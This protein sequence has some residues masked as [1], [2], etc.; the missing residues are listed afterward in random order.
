M[1][2]CKTMTFTVLVTVQG[3]DADYGDA[4]AAANYL[5]AGLEDAD[6]ELAENAENAGLAPSNFRITTGQPMAADRAACLAGVCDA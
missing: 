1:C 3:E 5:R 2:D 6:K 4:T